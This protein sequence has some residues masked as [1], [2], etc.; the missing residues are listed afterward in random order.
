MLFTAASIKT[1]NLSFQKLECSCLAILIVTMG[2][3][4]PRGIIKQL[5][6][7]I[8]VTQRKRVVE[9][10]NRFSCD[11]FEIAQLFRS[12]FEVL[13]RISFSLGNR[14]SNIQLQ[15]RKFINVYQSSTHIIQYV[16]HNTCNLV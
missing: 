16:F 15:I 8:K 14:S 13:T 1:L 5:T 6:K 4:F 2:V 10:V 3:H 11:H 7:T 9:L 12:R